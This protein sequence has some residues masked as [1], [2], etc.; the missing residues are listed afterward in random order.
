[1]CSSVLPVP[2]LMLALM[3]RCP[4]CIRSLARSSMP[5]ICD[6]GTSSI[7]ELRNTCPTPTSSVSSCSGRASAMQDFGQFL[8]REMR[9]LAQPDDNLQVGHGRFNEEYYSLWIDLCSA[10]ELGV[11]ETA[12]F[13]SAQARRGSS[14]LRSSRHPSSREPGRRGCGAPSPTCGS[15]CTTSSS[16]PPAQ[17]SS[18]PSASCTCRARARHA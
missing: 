9:L 7:V 11:Q 14:G 18:L 1:M 5:M 10:K 15:S 13:R 12:E 6:C 17:P 3:S 16:G 4:D 8:Q 2:G